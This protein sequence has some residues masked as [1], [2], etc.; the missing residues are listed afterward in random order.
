M[1]ELRPSSYGSAFDPITP[2]P[3]A[4]LFVSCPSAPRRFEQLVAPLYQLALANERE[5]QKL[6]ELRDALEP[7]LFSGRMT[8]KEAAAAV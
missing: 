7:E 1:G 8:V 2:D 4:S 5:S 6:A 3:L